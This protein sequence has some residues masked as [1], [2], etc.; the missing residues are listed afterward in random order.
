MSVYP[1]FRLDR[2]YLKFGVYKIPVYPGF[3]LAWSYL[4]LGVY[5]MPVYPGLRLDRTYLKL[6]FDFLIFLF[7]STVCFNYKFATDVNS[8][9][10]IYNVREYFPICN[11]KSSIYI[12][13][14]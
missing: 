13:S 11:T 3:S 10:V 7:S 8:N 2:S 14:L 12:R 5:K 6:R 1:G 4:K 9:I